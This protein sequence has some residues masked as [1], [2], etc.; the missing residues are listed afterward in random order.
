MS[1]AGRKMLNAVEMV[2]G[3]AQRAEK[4]FDRRAMTLQEKTNK[5]INLF[6]SNAGTQ[7]AAIA[8]ESRT[9]CDTLYASYQAL[10]KVLD[11]ECRP[12][13]AQDPDFEAVRAVAGMV[14]WL[15]D[16]S[17]IENNFTA[18]LNAYN[19]GDIVTVQYIPSIENKTIQTFWESKYQMFPGGAELEQKEKEEAD[20]KK[21]AEAEA[22]RIRY[23]SQKCGASG[24]D[25]ERRRLKDA[26]LETLNE[27]GM[28]TEEELR[29][30]C[31]AARDLASM[32][33][34][35]LL[36]S[37][38]E[39]KSVAVKILG[40]KMYFEA[41]KKPRTAAVSAENESYKRAI[42]QYLNDC[43]PSTVTEIA[44]GCYEV[45]GVSIPKLSEIVKELYMEG[46]LHKEENNGKAVFEVI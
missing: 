24:E 1:L 16:E 12:L 21:K 25:P 34:K 39:E 14:K 11:D 2:K 29:E 38:E 43:G 37:M 19:L 8:R 31:P 23:E 7:V 20:R 26:F 4:E 42:L 44:A 28:L 36:R 33:I 32:R 40:Y 13:L 41:L 5:V 45:A 9:I 3:K 18:S 46:K 15:N 22:R 17:E 35:I 6:G 27:H 10:V 30:H